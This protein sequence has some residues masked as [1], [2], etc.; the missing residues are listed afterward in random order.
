MNNLA[1][2]FAT[3]IGICLAPALLVGVVAGLRSFFFAFALLLTLSPLLPVAVCVPSPGDSCMPLGWFSLV[4]LS[5]LTPVGAAIF[6][7]AFA[8]PSKKTDT[9]TREVRQPS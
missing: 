8:I 6:I 2:L 3:G 1:I 7:G 9:R 4:A 5:I